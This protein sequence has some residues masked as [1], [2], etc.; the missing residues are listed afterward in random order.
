ML[1]R[2]MDTLQKCGLLYIPSCLLE[3]IH[4]SDDSTIPL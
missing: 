1:D 2:V 3:L 4:R